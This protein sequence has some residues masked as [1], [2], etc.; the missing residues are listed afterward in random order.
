M[1][2][3]FQPISIG[4]LTSKNRFVR[5]ATNDFLGNPDGSISARELDLYHALAENNVG[6]IISGHAYVQHPLGQASINQNAIYDDCFIAGYRSLADTVH[7]AGSKLV[8]QISHAGRQT[9]PKLAGNFQPMAP[10]AVTETTTG[11]T[12]RAMTDDEVWQL[13]DAFAAAMFRAKKAGSD[14]VQLHIAH[15]YALASFLSP[16]TNQRT[17][18]WGGNL[19]NRTRIL[20]EILLRG[21]R[22]VENDFPVLVKLNSTDGPVGETSLSLEDVIHAAQALQNWG[23]DAIEVSGGTRDTRTTMSKPGILK[24]EQ[25]AYFSTAAKSVRAAVNIPV[26]LVGGMRSFAVMEKVVS[27]GIADM[28]SLSRPLVKEPDLIYRFQNGKATQAACVSCNAC[29]NPEGLKCWR[30]K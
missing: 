5:S 18:M 23:V 12:P 26:I 17:D 13:I 19:E 10:S 21:R 4:T 14:G 2:V 9:A 8:I 25:E 30:T 29:F 3:L 24:P 15:G 28:I 20:R 27:E 6:I 7:A 22:L 11:I 16:Y 1:N